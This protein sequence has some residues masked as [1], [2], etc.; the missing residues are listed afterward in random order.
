MRNGYVKKNQKV[1]S[2]SE[3]EEEEEDDDDDHHH[4]L[5]FFFYLC[6][7]FLL[8]K[9]PHFSNIINYSFFFSA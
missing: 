9:L 2:Q 3:S 7:I 6:V 4:H 8:S 5:M 1:N